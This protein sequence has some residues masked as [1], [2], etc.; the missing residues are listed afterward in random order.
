LN[1]GKLSGSDKSEIGLQNV[2]S[3]LVSR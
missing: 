2:E 3:E 1:Y